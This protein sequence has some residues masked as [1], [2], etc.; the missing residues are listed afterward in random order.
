[1][2]LSKRQLDDLVFQLDNMEGVIEEDGVIPDYEGRGMA[3]GRSCVAFVVPTRHVGGLALLR[4]GAALAGTVDAGVDEGLINL[5]LNRAQVDGYG[6]DSVVYFVGI[7]V[8]G[9]A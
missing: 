4:F 5:M 9:D 8:E 2:Q 3:P 1:M 6:I 7:A